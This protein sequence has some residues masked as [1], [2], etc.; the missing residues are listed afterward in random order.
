M[1]QISYQEAVELMAFGGR[2][3]IYMGKLETAHDT[4]INLLRDKANEGIAFFVDDSEAWEKV[5][6]VRK[7]EDNSE[8]E[9]TPH[10][11]ICFD[12]KEID[13]VPVPLGRKGE[14]VKLL[15]SAPADDLSESVESEI[16]AKKPKT[17]QRQLPKPAKKKIDKGKIMA[18]HNAG[19]SGKKIADEMGVSQGTVSTYLK[20][21]KMEEKRDDNENQ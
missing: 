6:D 2:T 3:D 15:K 12:G 11:P 7:P 14:T 18:L 17:K 10:I 19:W 9:E 21:M 8:V 5:R 4:P 16:K 1:K 20:E 13:E